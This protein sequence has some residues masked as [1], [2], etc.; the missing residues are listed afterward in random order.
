M[1]VLRGVFSLPENNAPAF[2]LWFKP[3][4]GYD[5][6]FPYDI[7]IV[8]VLEAGPRVFQGKC[9]A[10]LKIILFQLAPCMKWVSWIKL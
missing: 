4:S 1:N 3:W 10:F 7:S 2:K 9:Y 8:L 6:I 5:Q